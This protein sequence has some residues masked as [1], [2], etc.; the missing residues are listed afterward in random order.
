VSA[1]PA[2]DHH[3]LRDAAYADA[4]RLRA[5]VDLYRFRV[6]P[7]DFLSWVL[8]HVPLSAAG[9][10]IDL[11][12]GD[13]RLLARLSQGG[14]DAVGIDLAEGMLHQARDTSPAT[15]LVCGDAA[16]LPLAS[17][18]ADVVFALHML[19]H[20]ADLSAALAEIGR[21]LRPGGRLVATTNAGHHL[22]ELRHLTAR[23]AADVAGS[24]VLPAWATSHADELFLLEDALGLLAAAGFAIE[25]FDITEAQVVLTE[26]GP[27]MAY[28]D[29]TAPFRPTTVNWEQ[30]VAAV[31]DRI[32]DA[33]ATGGAWTATVA[34]GAVVAR[35][36]G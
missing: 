8:A 34:S 32:A 13:G 16:M 20:V 3:V 17:A 27:A 31:G 2:Q 9:R 30:V 25:T 23:A 10:M 5:R 1:G 24:A 28:V 29:S 7:I 21:V 12:C 15:P 11:G 26:P 4:S 33:V 6:P 36:P 18:H 22:A 35:W 14:L 19:Y